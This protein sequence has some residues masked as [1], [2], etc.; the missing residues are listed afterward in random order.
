MKIKCRFRASKVNV[1]D[2]WLLCVRIEEC[3]ENDKEQVN[4]F[5]CLIA[6]FFSS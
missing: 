3:T 6:S 4:T 1:S 5:T 2:P